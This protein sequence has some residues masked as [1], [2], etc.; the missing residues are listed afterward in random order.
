MSNHLYQWASSLY[1]P[2][3]LKIIKNILNEGMIRANDA[4]PQSMS[5]YLKPH[6]AVLRPKPTATI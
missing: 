3:D 1:H 4:E 2:E 5:P 6:R